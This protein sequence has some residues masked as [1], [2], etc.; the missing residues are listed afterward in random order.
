MGFWK[1]PILGLLRN[2]F[3]LPVGADKQVR[4]RVALL[5]GGI[6]SGSRRVERV[7]ARWGESERIAEAMGAANPRAEAPECFRCG[8]EVARIGGVGRVK[9]RREVDGAPLGIHAR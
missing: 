4:R 3:I 6:H 1:G 2:F 9:R 8:G 7:H 5:G